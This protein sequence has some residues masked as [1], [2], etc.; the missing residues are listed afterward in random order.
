MNMKN[1]ILRRSVFDILMDIWYL[2]T[3]TDYIKFLIKPILYEITPEEATK[4][5]EDFDPHVRNFFLTKGIINLLPQTVKSAILPEENFNNNIND[6]K[7]I[8][9]EE[10]SSDSTRHTHENQRRT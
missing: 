9:N 10:N 3:L 1:L 4:V 6:E 2:P 5:L 8:K 7:I